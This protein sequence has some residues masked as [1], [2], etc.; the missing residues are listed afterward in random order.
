MNTVIADPAGS[1]WTFGGSIP[2]SASSIPTSGGPNLTSGGSMLTFTFP[3]LPVIVVTRT[4]THGE[5][6]PEG[7][8]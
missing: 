1:A 7:G 6:V 8:E 2:T 4:A 5:Q 3:M